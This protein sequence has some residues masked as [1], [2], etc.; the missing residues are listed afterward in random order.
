MH[1]D[2][3][4]SHSLESVLGTQDAEV[5]VYDLVSPIS[6]SIHVQDVDLT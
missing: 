2:T 1:S 6:T 5:L 4:I 3:V